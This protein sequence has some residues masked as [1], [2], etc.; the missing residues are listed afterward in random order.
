MPDEDKSPRGSG[1]SRWDSPPLLD[2]LGPCP[3]PWPAKPAKFLRHDIRTLV[4]PVPPTRFPQETRPRTS[5]GGPGAEGR[6][7]GA[8]AQF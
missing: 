6:R 4:L 5:W 1:G 8:R 3:G 7:S 2:C